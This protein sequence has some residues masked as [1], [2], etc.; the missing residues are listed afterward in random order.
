VGR[1]DA[2]IGLRQDSVLKQSGA[3]FGE[4]GRFEDPVWE[5]DGME[6]NGDDHLIWFSGLDGGSV[7]FDGDGEFEK[8]DNW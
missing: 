4:R 6:W 3:S 2:P 1:L 5:E 7:E 8:I